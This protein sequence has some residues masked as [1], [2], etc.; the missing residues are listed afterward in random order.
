[1]TPHGKVLD[2]AA[3]ATPLDFAYQIHTDVGHRCR[4]AKVNGSMVPLTYTLKSGDQVEV[5]T[6]RNGAPSRDWLS[7]HLGYLKTARARA[8]VR[9]WFKEQDYEKNLASGQ[10]V[11]QRELRRL[12]IAN[13]DRDRLLARFNYTRFEDLLAGIG[14]GDVSGAQLASALQQIMPERPVA[15]APEPRRKRRTKRHT[16][17]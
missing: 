13:P 14:H 6:T 17:V 3:G 5:L 12:G 2:L 10:D 9:H 16:G 8:K 11:F 4:G 15:P 1:V 7:P